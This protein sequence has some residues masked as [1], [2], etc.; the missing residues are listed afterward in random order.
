MTVGFSGFVIREFPA[1]GLR[2]RLRLKPMAY[3]EELRLYFPK[4][5]RFTRRDNIREHP[6]FYTSASPLLFVSELLGRCEDDRIARRSC[7]FT[8]VSI[9]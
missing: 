2:P 5:Y 1:I 3:R 7:N 8:R 6:A 4:Y 9:F